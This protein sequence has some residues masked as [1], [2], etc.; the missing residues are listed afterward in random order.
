L[1]SGSRQAG[2]P[3]NQGEGVADRPLG[4]GHE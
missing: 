1:R 4:D 3:L 2:G